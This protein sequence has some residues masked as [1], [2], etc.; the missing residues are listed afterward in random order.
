VLT[1]FEA[2]GI[3]LVVGVV[4]GITSV[5]LGRTYEWVTL[6]IMDGLMALPFLIFAIAVAA[7][8]GNAVQQAMVA[9][10]VLIAPAFYRVTRAAA[11]SHANAQYVTASQL[12]GA[13]VWRVVRTHVWSKILPTLVVTTAN[14]TAGALLIVSSLTFLGIGVVP[15]NPTWGGI[16]ASDLSYLSQAPYAPLFPSLLIMVTVGALNLLADAIKDTSDDHGRARLLQRK[17]RRE[18]GASLA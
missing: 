17:K 18:T 4:P 13:S 10:G 2:V 11:L 3:G 6:R 9:V 15:P 14:A 1:A 12:F 16:L 8:L 7:L 5:Y